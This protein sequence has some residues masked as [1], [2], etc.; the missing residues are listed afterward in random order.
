M[1]LPA[2]EEA[3]CVALGYR[4]CAVATSARNV[5][6]FSHTGRA[7]ATWTC[8]APVVALAGAAD[9]T[10]AVCEHEARG[11]LR[12][13]QAL[14]VAVYSLADDRR[15]RRLRERPLPLS[16]GATLGWFGFTRD[17]VLAAVDSA[18]VV[19]LCCA[20]LD[21]EWSPVLDA[22]AQRKTKHERQWVVG[23]DETALICIHCKVER[24]LQ[25]GGAAAANPA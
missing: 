23:I 1:T 5:R 4:F 2:G 12:D 22:S 10:L 19:R 25:G 17:G 6:V 3:T 15:V 24:A 16:A 8:R 7:I 20:A 13:E 11:A 14:R 9:G 21:Y 18:A